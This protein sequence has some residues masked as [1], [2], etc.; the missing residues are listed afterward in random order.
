[1]VVRLALALL[2]VASLATA[3][4]WWH[5]A[6]PVPLADGAASKL[7]CLSY[8]PS[9]GMRRRAPGAA[10]DITTEQLRSDLAV[11][12]TRTRCVRTYT[13]AGGFDQVP[14][15]AREFGLE[16]LLGVWIGRDADH[17]EREIAIATRVARAHPDVIRALVVGNEVLLRQELPEEKLAPLIRRVAANSGLPVTYADVWGRWIDHKA[18]AADVSFVTVH[19]LPYWDDEPHGIDEVIRYVDGLCESLQAAFPGRK[20]FIGETGWPSAGRPRGPAVPSRVNQARYLREFTVLA[21][22]RG[23]DYNVIETFD[24]PWKIPHEGTVGGHWG[25]LDG[26]RREKFEWSGPVVESP[27]G[28]IVALAALLAGGVAALIAG[29]AAALSARRK[30]APFAE[31][32]A[33]LVG[34]AAAARFAETAQAGVIRRR[35]FRA[36]R[37]IVSFAAAALSVSVGVRQWQ[38][39]IDGN[40]T[41]L[42]WLATASIC[43]TGRFAFLFA[44]RALIATEPTRDSTRGPTHDPMPRVLA[45]ALL[46][47][48][49]YICLGLIFAGRH[50]DFPLWLF[51]PGVLAMVTTALCSPAARLRA[52]RER[53]ANEEVLLATWLVVAG[54]L[55]PVLERTPGGL[56]LAWGLACVLLG[57]SV[58][59]PLALQSRND[60]R[61]GQHARGRQGEVVQHHAPGAND[62]G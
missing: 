52:L 42:A 47:A 51:V 12:S 58:L 9:G 37:A 60:E 29:V 41:W 14:A 6:R 20:L 5:D 34:E 54:V 4:S 35:N 21:A 30:A 2:V 13:V 57:A 45:L 22:R 39:L 18:L 16:V 27:R 25:L 56:A 40:V 33:A 17:N 59:A 49:A 1:V 46:V 3:W 19:I 31:S 11:L 28:R 43:L 32:E 38:F 53:R 15:V 10:I 36:R 44:M 7:P 24:Q 55:I 62:D 8:A 50:R 26:E 23:F 48:A 61:A